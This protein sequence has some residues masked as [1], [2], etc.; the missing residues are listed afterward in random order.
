MEDDSGYEETLTFLKPSAITRGLIGEIIG[1][2]ESKGL[3]ILALKLISMTR[4]E[5]ELLYAEHRSKTFYRELVDVV[6]GKRIV[7]LILRGRDAVKVVRSMIGATNPV[8]AAP[9]T[10]RGD[11]GLE[12]TDN[13]IHASDSKESFQREVEILFPGWKKA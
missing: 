12:M 5:A 1:R 13:L 8:E 3:E 10:V 11:Y 9:G 4:D 6:S 7:A 2:F